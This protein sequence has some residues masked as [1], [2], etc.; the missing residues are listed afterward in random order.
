MGGMVE[1]GWDIMAC[2]EMI[3]RRRFVH[4]GRFE[5]LVCCFAMW[6]TIWRWSE[7]MLA[8]LGLRFLSLFVI[9]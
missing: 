9:G 1:V 2:C 5:F 6:M 7:W 3:G 4:D 8:F